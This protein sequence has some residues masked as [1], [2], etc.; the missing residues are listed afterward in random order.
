MLSLWQTAADERKVNGRTVRLLA[1]LLAGVVTVL[2]F[3][4]WAVV[5]AHSPADAVRPEFSVLARFRL[6]CAI[7]VASYPTSLLLLACPN[8]ARSRLAYVFLASALSAAWALPA[9]D[10][11]EWDAATIAVTGIAVGSSA[12]CWW[13]AVV[14][15]WRG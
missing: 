11:F 3:T 7:A 2:L 13:L 14:G 10:S 4:A 5:A 8:T 15:W 1:S 9:L 6:S 12:A